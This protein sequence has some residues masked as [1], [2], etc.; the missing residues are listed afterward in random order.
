MALAARGLAGDEEVSHFLIAR[1]AFEQPSLFLSLVG[2]PLV[3]LALALPAQAGLL[4]ARLA[5]VLASTYCAYA[6]AR[7]ARASGLGPPWLAVVFLVLQ[8]FF[9]A[10]CGTA[11][12]EPWAAALLAGMI[13]AVTEKRHRSLIALAAIFPL[14][15]M[16]AMVFWPAVVLWELG[17][18]ARSWLALLPLPVFALAGAGALLSGDPL[19]VLHQSRWPAYPEREPFHYLRSWVWTL[20]LGLFAPAILGMIGA[21]HEAGRFDGPRSRALSA[22][23]LATAILFVVYSALAAWRPITFG[24]LRYIAYAAPALAILAL[25]GVHEISAGGL[26][27][28]HWIALAFTLVAAVFLWGHPWIR[29][30]AMLRR[31]DVWPGVMAVI[32]M[33]FA[34]AAP[35]FPSARAVI[36]IGGFLAL[37]NLG[38]VAL[39]HRD[40]LHWKDIPEHEAVRTAARILPGELPAGVRLYAAHALLAWERGVNPY[41]PAAW[42]PITDRLAKT[43][44]AGTLLFWDTHYVAGKSP[45]LELRGIIDSHAWKYGGGTVARDSSWAGCFFVRSGPGEDVLRGALHGGLPPHTWLEAARLVQYGIPSGR[46]NVAADPENAEMWR[47][48]ALRYFTAG[49]ESQ[50]QSALDRARS[51][52][53]QNSKNEAYAAEMHRLSREF[54]QAIEEADK[55]LALSPGNPNFEY[56]LGRILLDEGKVEDAVPHLT[57]GAA[58]LPKRPEMQLDAGLALASLGRWGE[59]RPFLERAAAL[60]PNEV[61]AVIGLMQVDAGEGKESA[62]IARARGFIARRPEVADMYLALGDLLVRM[63]RAADARAVWEEGSRKTNDPEI[64]G[65]L[66]ANPHP[67]VSH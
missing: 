16:E 43:A 45:V 30:F 6:V 64:A 7:T 3:T 54:P 63:G 9:L 1:H 22:S 14:A 39:R 15:R 2:R 27:A 37:V 31:R 20:G 46:Q 44:T 4:A 41:D 53:P 17:S 47:Q 35:R 23:A 33:V 5:S 51:L 65:K 67:V 8:P 66:Q 34:L 32:W 25:W 36:W 19:W 29:D 42:P 50:A 62:A 24:N 58:G 11:M 40:T 59:A 55:A 13:L 57:A 12:T 28:Y 48:L 61:K 18:P 21:V 10:H 60:R 38:D 52:E 26:R 49:F 56:L